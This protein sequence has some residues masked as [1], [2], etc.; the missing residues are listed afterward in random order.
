MKC[1]VCQHDQVPEGAESCPSCGSDL[2]AFQ[3]ISHVGTQ[4][5]TYKMTNIALIILILLG[6]ATLGTVRVMNSDAPQ[7]VQASIQTDDQDAEALAV[8]QQQLT[9]KDDEIAFLKG[10]VES[11]LATIES[12]R[13]DVEEGDHIIHVVAPGESLWSISEL[14][15]GHGFQHDEIADHNEVENVHHIKVGDT[16]II[17]KD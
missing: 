3:L 16:I 7:P 10:E 1:P 4:R 6:G 13:S 2:R 11:L 15:H 14:Y 12:S 8:A 9:E 17:K 5:R